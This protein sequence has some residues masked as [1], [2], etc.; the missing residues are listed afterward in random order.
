MLPDLSDTRIAAIEITPMWAGDLSI[1]DVDAAL[2]NAGIVD[3]LMPRAPSHATCMRRAFDACSPRGARIDPLPKG[4]GVTMSLKDVAML[5]L[6]ALA[7]QAGGVVREAAS[8]HATFTA[9]ILVQNVNGTEI[10]QLSFSPDDHPMIP[11]VREMYRVKREQ[12]KASEDLSIWFSQTIIPAV[13][14]VGKRSRGGVYYVAA[15]RRDTIVRVAQ[16]L[17]SLSYSTQIDRVVNGVKVPVH[18]LSHGGKL[19]IEPRYADDSAAMEI[20]ID[21]VIRDADSTLDNLTASLDVPDGKRPLGKRALA[22]KREACAELERQMLAWENVCSVSLDLLRDRVKEL[23]NAIGTAE[24]A[25]ELSSL[26]GE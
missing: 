9:K 18:R 3:D 24:L 5:D 22:T 17:E 19:C 21:V 8:Y 1:V 16:A 14:G 6:E 4:M 25:A 26:T 15:H 23:Q 12:Y 20:M 7:A 11:L 2:K 13:G 10:E